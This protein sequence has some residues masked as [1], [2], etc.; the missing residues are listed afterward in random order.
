MVALPLQT[1]QIVIPNILVSRIGTMICVLP[2]PKTLH[3][4]GK[5]PALEALRTIHGAEPVVIA[6]AG[7]PPVRGGVDHREP[8]S[9]SLVSVGEITDPNQPTRLDSSR[10][11]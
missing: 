3:L 8:T 11:T 10:S 4:V 9:S 5:R 1:S 2:E 6:G 7:L